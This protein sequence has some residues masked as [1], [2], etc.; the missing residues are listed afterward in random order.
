MLN[1]LLPILRNGFAN[2]EMRKTD[3]AISNFTKAHELEPGNTI[4]VKELMELYFNYRQYAKAVELAQLCKDCAKA[5]RIIALSY[6]QQKELCKSRKS[7][8]CTYC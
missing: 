3:A 7:I 2:L 1:L 5:E 6:F 8:A 4:P